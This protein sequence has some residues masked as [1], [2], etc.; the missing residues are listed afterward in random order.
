MKKTPPSSCKPLVHLS[1][2]LCT[3]FQTVDYVQDPFFLNVS[4]TF[5]SEECVRQLPLGGANMQSTKSHRVC[6][7]MRKSSV[8][9]LVM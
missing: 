9:F 1:C 6:T 5:S 3:V 4:L 7:V 8:G 2:F